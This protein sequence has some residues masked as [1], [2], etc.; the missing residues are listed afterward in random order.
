MYFFFSLQNRK[1]YFIGV[2][3]IAGF[4]IFKVISLSLLTCYLLKSFLLHRS[5]RLSSC[6]STL[7]TRSSNSS[8]IITCLS[9]NRRSTRRRALNGNSLTLALTF[10]LALTLLRRYDNYIIILISGSECVCCCVCYYDIWLS[11]V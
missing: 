7:R 8:S 4:E 10:S 6:A 9:L 1:A 5:T 3:D 2:L 11:L